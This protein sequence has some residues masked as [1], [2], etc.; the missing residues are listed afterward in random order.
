MEYNL[1]FRCQKCSEKGGINPAL[2][3]LLKLVN[4]KVENFNK[5]VN[6]LQNFQDNIKNIKADAK[7]GAEAKTKVDNVVNVVIPDLKKKLRL[8]RKIVLV[9]KIK[10]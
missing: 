7:S 10:C 6:I 8:A 3:D 5:L 9:R 2:Q 4:E 1:V